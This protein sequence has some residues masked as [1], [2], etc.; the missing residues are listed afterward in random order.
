MFK[1]KKDTKALDLDQQQISTLIGYG[2]EIKGEISGPSVIRIEGSVIG[3]V[4]TEGG[5]ILG[6]KGKI[7]GNITTQS[8]IIHGNVTGNV[9]AVQL[10]IKK[11]GFVN[12]DIKTETLEIEL[13]AQYNGK[14]EMNQMIKKSEALPQEA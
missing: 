3:N 13:G 4:T 2:Y 6:E 14:L 5:L 8:A 12:G 10:E 1:K 7:T 9:R 11:T